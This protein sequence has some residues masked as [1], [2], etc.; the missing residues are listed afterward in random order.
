M[1]VLKGRPFLSNGPLE[2]QPWSECV[3]D[4]K[5]DKTAKRKGDKVAE[6]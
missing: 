2:W 5:R 1:D 4:Y 3:S 6:V